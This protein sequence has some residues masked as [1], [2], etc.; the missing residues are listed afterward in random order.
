MG[1]TYVK[2]VEAVSDAKKNFDLPFIFILTNGEM[3]GPLNG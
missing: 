3:E 1:W 2:N